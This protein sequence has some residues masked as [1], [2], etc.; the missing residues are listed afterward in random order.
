M[1][2]FCFVDGYVMVCS[3]LAKDYERN[4][5][6]R[7]TAEQVADASGRAL[8]VAE[9]DLAAVTALLQESEAKR[10][11]AQEIVSAARRKRAAAA[12]AASSA[13]GDRSSTEI[14][15]CS[16][17]KRASLDIC[18]CARQTPWVMRSGD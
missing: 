7:G 13:N 12:K 17:S 11:K 16:C 5:C 8:A 6:E 14:R 4:E 10:A 18:C 9:K 1:A 3:N 2:G 15:S